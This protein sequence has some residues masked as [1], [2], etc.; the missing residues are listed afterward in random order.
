V[1]T[2]DYFIAKLEA[3]GKATYKNMTDG[4][5]SVNDMTPPLPPISKFVDASYVQ[6]AWK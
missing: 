1:D 6:E 3:F 2:Y 5:I 4:P